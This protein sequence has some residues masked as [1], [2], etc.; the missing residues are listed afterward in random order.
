MSTLVVDWYRQFCTYVAKTQAGVDTDKVMK[1]D[2]C[3]EMT[4]ETI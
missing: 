3:M 2:L 4:F 1:Q